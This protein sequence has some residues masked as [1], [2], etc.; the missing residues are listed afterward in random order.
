MFGYLGIRAL[1]GSGRETSPDL[2]LH[3]GDT[4]RARHF[5]LE[6]TLDNPTRTGPNHVNLT[7]TSTTFSPKTY[8]SLLLLFL[9]QFSSLFHV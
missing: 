5:Y 6:D 4:S 8:D 2:D 3:I 1:K 9:S 7:T